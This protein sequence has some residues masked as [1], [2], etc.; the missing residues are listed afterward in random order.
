MASLLWSLLLAWTPAL[1]VADPAPAAE[2]PNLVPDPSFEEAG[3]RGL[4]AGWT[5]FDAGMTTVSFARDTEVTHTGAASGRITVS[6]DV[7][8]SWPALT[9]DLPA[10]PGQCY[11]V[12]AWVITRD[13]VRLAYI[14]AEYLDAKGQRLGFTPGPSAS[15][16]TA[17]WRRLSLQA[18]VPDGTVTVS[19]HLILYGSGTAWFDD[20]WVS[21]DEAY[22]QAL[23]KMLRPLPP[24]LVEA[25]TTHV[26][27]LSRLHRLFQA[28]ATGGTYTVGI[29]GGSITGG[30]VASCMERHYSA[31]V[32]NWLKEHFPQAEWEFV[33][34][35]IGATGTNYGCLRAQR[36]LLSKQPDLVVSEFAVNDAPDQAS[37]E[38]YEGL[39][40][41]ILASPKQPALL[42]LFMMNEVGGNAQEIQSRLG[43]HYDLPMLSYR[44]MLWPEV[45]AGRMTWRDLSPDEV[46]PHDVGHGYAGKLLTSLLDRAL[47]SLPA[48][49]VPA[50]SLSLPAPLFTDLYQF[51]QLSEAEDLRPVANTGWTYDG[52]DA[53][54]KHWKA[55]VPGSVIEF[56]VT[57]EQLFVSHFRLRAG[58]GRARLTLDGGQPTVLD[59]WFE[60]TWGGYRHT[61]R[62][63]TGSP[64]THRV[65]LEL[66]DEK[67]SES[68]GNEF[69]L[70][71]L[72]TAGQ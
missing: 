48:T 36:D 27:D 23:A 71:C 47:A 15:G 5:A 28:A 18:R 16:T 6:S 33:N 39:V 59:A 50:P 29:I 65:R 55:T 51:A 43:A 52:N 66:L 35:G 31:Y 38:T 10:Q 54:G 8:P 21:R 70:L 60:G 7:N 19:L 53:W 22:E 62:F 68:T 30:G 45:Q 12:S 57:G 3:E 20:A 14:T 42:M 63:A 4:P 37:A 11:Q 24:E 26:G 1:C 9:W 32:V 72:G 40:R 46:H 13:V 61:T 44:D 67:A 56:D 17:D 49:P 2:P 34:A 58:M 25:G 64:G 69:R 41:Q